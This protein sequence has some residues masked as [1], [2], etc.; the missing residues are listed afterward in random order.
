MGPSKQLVLAHKSLI[1]LLLRL[2]SSPEP[3]QTFRS[4]MFMNIMT[5]LNSSAIDFVASDSSSSEIVSRIL[6]SSFSYVPEI[7]LVAMSSVFCEPWCFNCYVA[8]SF[9]VCPITM[10]TELH[11]RTAHFP[12]LISPIPH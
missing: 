4:K 2:G 1:N 6:S 11:S 3:I 7:S 12:P 10:A 9:L 5:A 8:V